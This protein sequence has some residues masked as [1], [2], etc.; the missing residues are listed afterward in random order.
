MVQQKCP[1]CGVATK[2]GVKFCTYC[3]A[4]LSEVNEAATTSGAPPKLETTDGMLIKGWEVSPDRLDM[5]EKMISM[6]DVGDLIITSKSKLDNE[7]GLLLVSEKG[8]AWRI[9]M[10][11]RQASIMRAAMSSGKHKWVRWHDVAGFMPKKPGVLIIELKIRK[12]GSLLKDKKGNYKIKKWKFTIQP[13]KK[14]EKV[15]FKERQK[16]FNDIMI[17]LHSKYKGDT[18]PDTSDS[19]M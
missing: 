12:K 1:S 13:N 3:G 7:N 16:K 5:Y 2:I 10:G 8:F 19:R 11:M 14:E 15:H 17:D 6:D 4:E 18:D 9:K